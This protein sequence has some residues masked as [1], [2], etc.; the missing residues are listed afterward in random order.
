MTDDIDWG[1]DALIQKRGGYSTQLKYEDRQKLRAIVKRVHMRNY[2]TEHLTD[3]EADRIIDV[4]APE[5][6]EY[7]VRKHLHG[8]TV[9]D[10]IGRNTR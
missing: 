6:A 4:I 3:R 8:E 7:L 10:A 5:T 1:L 2:P 9:R